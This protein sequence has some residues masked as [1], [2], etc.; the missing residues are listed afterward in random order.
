MFVSV[1]LYVHICFSQA[2][3][4]SLRKHD[5][6]VVSKFYLWKVVDYLEKL[7]NVIYFMRIRK[8][9]YILNKNQIKS[10]VLII[11]V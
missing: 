5:T 3:L 8:G 11:T 6:T 2:P 10:Y 7:F 4:F 9:I 1:F